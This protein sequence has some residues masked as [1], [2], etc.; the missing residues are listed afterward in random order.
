MLDIAKNVESE[1]K[2]IQCK[3]ADSEYRWIQRKTADSVYGWSYDQR[4]D[5]TK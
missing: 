4:R 2:W 1:Y 3:I 5:V